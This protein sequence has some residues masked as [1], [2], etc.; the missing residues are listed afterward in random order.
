MSNLRTRHVIFC[1]YNPQLSFIN[2]IQKKIHD[3]YTNH[4]YGNNSN[5]T[6]NVHPQR[7]HELLAQHNYHHL[8]YMNPK[9]GGDFSFKFQ[10]IVICMNKKLDIDDIQLVTS[11]SGFTIVYNDD[12]T[13]TITINK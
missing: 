3:W 11:D 13:C 7:F 1:K 8:F 12:E 2:Q 10:G 6:I 5:A 9:I 4:R